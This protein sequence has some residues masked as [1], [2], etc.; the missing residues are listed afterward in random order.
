MTLMQDAQNKKANKL[1]QA[2]ATAENLSEDFIREGVADGTIVIP[3]N[4]NRK[5]SKIIAV[6]KGLKTKVNANIGTSPDYINLEEELVKLD[7]A[8][9][10]GADAVMDLSTGGN[11]TQ[12]RKEILARCPVQVGT[13]PIYEAACR[14]VAQ[15]KKISQ[16]DGEMLFDVIEEQAQ[17]GVDFITVHCGINK[18]TVE[19]LNR[20][21]RLAGVVSRGGSFLVKCI[22]ATGK[23]NPL[24]AQYDR[25]LA[26]A[27]KYDV[28][29]SL[30]DGFR[31]G[32]AFDASDA[33][34]LGELAVLG[35]L[36]LKARAAGVQTMIEG[37][38]HV[39]LNQIEA[40]VTLAKKLGHGAPLYF[41]GPLV[42]DIAPG[43]DH[44]TSAIGGALAA[45]KGVDFICYVTPAEHIRLPNVKDVREGVIAAR[46][47]GH[48][49]DIVKGVKGAKDQDDAMSKYRKLRDWKKQEEFCIDP[50]KLR[51]E[52][53]KL[54]PQQDDVCTMCGEFCAMRDE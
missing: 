41:L 5:L 31:P 39:P 27:K 20:Q 50:E 3:K 17:Q 36:V 16:I 12:I 38:G 54:P 51:T 30:G 49:A 53:A 40:N 33:V 34:Q 6:G 13:V 44:I 24:Y 47:A 26:I 25:L 29:L 43:Y 10:A 1:I 4:I 45:A 48:A 35:E 21:G 19:I 14:T 52:R 2:A 18:A 22:N 28:T 37:P 9:K 32:A 11:L 7:V 8:V 15:G 42:T 23:E 46:I